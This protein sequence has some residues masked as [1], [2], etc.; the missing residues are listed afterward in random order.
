M[1]VSF[2]LQ[3]FHSQEKSAGS[4]RGWLEPISGLNRLLSRKENLCRKTNSDSHI[5][6]AIAQL[7]YSK[8]STPDCTQWVGELM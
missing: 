6:Q 4:L 8:A 5:V 2:T 1:R 3:A 7:I